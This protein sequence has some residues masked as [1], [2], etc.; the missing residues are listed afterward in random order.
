[1]HTKYKILIITLIC[2]LCLF[3]YLYRNWSNKSDGDTD[4]RLEVCDTKRPYFYYQITCK[5]D[6]AY[7]FS[8]SRGYTKQAINP[9]DATRLRELTT[10]LSAKEPFIYEGNEDLLIDYDQHYQF[11]YR[12]HSLKM[13]INGKLSVFI[14]GF[15]PSFLPKEYRPILDVT[16]WLN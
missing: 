4:I 9:S 13:Y 1:M 12:T 8:P 2:V 10:I 15:S 3:G 5:N 16:C 11:E 14:A 6:T 7:F